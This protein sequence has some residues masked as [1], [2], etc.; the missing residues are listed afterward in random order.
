MAVVF[1]KYFCKDSASRV[2]CKQACK[3][4]RRS[5]SSAK[6]V[7]GTMDKREKRKNDPRIAQFL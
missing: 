7:Q 1:K 3:W 6:M 5:L 4:P 2:L